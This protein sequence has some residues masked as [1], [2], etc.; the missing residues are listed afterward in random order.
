[1]ATNKV[2]PWYVDKRAEA[3]VFSLFAG[4]DL[5]VRDQEHQDF[6]VDFVLDLRKDQ[7]ELGRNLAIQV[8]AYVSFPKEADLNKEIARRLPPRLREDFMFPLAAFAIQVKELAAVY[9]WVLE[10]VAEKGEATLHSP[11]EY[12]WK[13][14][15]DKAMDEILARVDAFW[16]ALL[17]MVKT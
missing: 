16:D 15:D 9:T 17:K 4:R 3:F 8:L 1:M 11:R 5:A 7:R 2:Q 13:M 12:E 6:G 14:L 10:P